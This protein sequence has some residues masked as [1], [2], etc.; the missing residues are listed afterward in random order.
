MKLDLFVKLKYQSSTVILF[1][2][3]R[4]SM[5]DQLSDPNNYMPDSQTSDMRQIR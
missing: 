3:N 2:D 4:Y 5:R 1:L